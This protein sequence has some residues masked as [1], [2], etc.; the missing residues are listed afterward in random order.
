ML[1]QVEWGVQNEPITKT[2][3]LPVTTLYF[4]I[5]F[6]L[7]NLLKIVDLMYQRPKCPYPYFL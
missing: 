6:Q 7:E 3:V 4:L 1:R 2:G 5:L